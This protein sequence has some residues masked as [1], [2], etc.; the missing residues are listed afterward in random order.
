MRNEL[1]NSSTDGHTVINTG[2]GIYTNKRVS[3]AGHI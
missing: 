1:L 2:N 3:N